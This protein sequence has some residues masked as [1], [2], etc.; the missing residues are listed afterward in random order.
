MSNELKK[1]AGELQREGTLE[2]ALDEGAGVRSRILRR[3]LCRRN[4]THKGIEVSNSP[5]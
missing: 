5:M 3:N 2:E 4:S 1:L